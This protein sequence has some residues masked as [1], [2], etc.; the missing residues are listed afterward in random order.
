MIDLHC[1]VLPGVDDG[2]ATMDESLV[3]A[4]IICETGVQ[5]VAA[6][7]HLREDHPRV[8]PAELATRTRE[9]NDELRS[10]NIDLLIVAGG[11]V[12]LWWAI[13]ATNADLQLVSFQ[14]RGTD[15][16]VETPYGPLPDTFEELLFDIRAKG[17]RVVLAHPER[18]PSFQDDPERL[19]TL[20]HQGVLLQVTAS[21]LVARARRS[22]SRHLAEKLIDQRLAHV[23]ASDGHG[24]SHIKRV[25]LSDGVDALAAIDPCLVP[26]MTSA[27]PSAILDGGP[28]P[29]P[30]PSTGARRGWW[31]PRTGR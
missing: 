30:P 22:R 29:E 7:P 10:N 25:T 6:T 21:S 2:P 24:V 14:Q 1:H 17:F 23:L 26:W 3:L 27:V 12:D 8:L 4:R 9:L 31:R 11:E 20:V 5:V 15:L 16:L 18:N 19:Y 13:T 28:V